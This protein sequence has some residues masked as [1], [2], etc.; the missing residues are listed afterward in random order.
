[1]FV[2]EP[3]E[4]A[5]ETYEHELFTR[6]RETAEMSAQNLQLFFGESA[7]GSV[8]EIFNRLASPKHD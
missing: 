5:L 1:M 7:P 8:V 6:T 2:L 3:V 4:A